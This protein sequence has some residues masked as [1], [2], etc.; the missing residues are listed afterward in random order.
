MKSHPEAQ[1]VAATQELPVLS[2]WTL[3]SLLDG[4]R[5]LGCRSGPWGP[6][7]PEAAGWNLVSGTR[8]FWK[9]RMGWRGGLPPGTLLRLLPAPPTLSQLVVFGAVLLSGKLETI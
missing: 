8:S 2:S 6:W 3:C 5:A 7:E 4:N 9:D 1:R